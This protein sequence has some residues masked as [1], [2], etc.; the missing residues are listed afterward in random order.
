MA[1]KQK[2]LVMV[3]EIVTSEEIALALEEDLKDQRILSLLAAMASA[4]LVFLVFIALL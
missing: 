3:D 4:G 2:A 1:V